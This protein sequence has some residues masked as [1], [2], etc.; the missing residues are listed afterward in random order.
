MSAPGNVN[1]TFD[2]K[3]FPR[4]FCLGISINGLFDFGKHT[5]EHGK[6]S[7]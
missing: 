5:V 4:S 3:G 6:S 7:H 2:D 1:C